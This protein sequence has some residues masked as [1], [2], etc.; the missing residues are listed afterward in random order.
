MMYG[1]ADLVALR[2]ADELMSFTNEVRLIRNIVDLVTHR[3]G[4]G[5]FLIGV[6]NINRTGRVSVSAD[7]RAAILVVEKGTFDYIA[8]FASRDDFAE[9]SLSRLDDEEKSLIMLPLYRYCSWADRLLE[10]EGVG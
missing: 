6:R 3:L 4:E 9:Y 2:L 7:P 8:K 5:S 10:N 1:Y